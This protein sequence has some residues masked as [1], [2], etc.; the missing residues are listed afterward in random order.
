M[1]SPSLVPPLPRL[2]RATD[3][4]PPPI[5]PCLTL[6]PFSAKFRDTVLRPKLPISLADGV[7]YAM[8]RVSPSHESAPSVSEIR[9][10]SRS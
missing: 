9:R 1:Q 5:P 7:H 2:A 10:V 4:R 8:A 6:G 3:P